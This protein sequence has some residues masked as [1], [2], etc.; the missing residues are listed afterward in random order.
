MTDGSAA[1][2][3]DDENNDWHVYMTENGVVQLRHNSVEQLET[4][5]GGVA[6]RGLNVGSHNNGNPHNANGIQVNMSTDEKIVLSG[7]NNP[8]I[9]W[10]EG[11]TDR[12]YIQWSSDDALL[13]KNQQ[14]DNFDF[15]THDTTGAV[16]IR[17][18]GSDNDTFGSVYG[19]NNSDVGQIGFLD[20]DQNWGYV[21]TGDTSHQWLINNSLKLRL[22]SSSLELDCGTSSTLNVK[23]DDAGLAMVRVNGDGQGTGAVEVGQSDTYGGGMFYNGDGS[24]AFASG[25]GSD[26][27][28]FYRMSNGTRTTVFSY[29]YSSNSV[30]FV[31]STVHPNIYIDDNVYHNGDSNTYYGFHAADQWRVVTGGSERL[32][33]NNTNTTVQN[34]LIVSGTATFN[35]TVS[36]I[37]AS[38][39]NG[40]FWE[41]DQ[42]ITSNQT[43]TNNKNA[44]SAGP[45]TINNNVTVTIG[46]GEAWSIV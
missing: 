36:G 25:E 44:M 33:V 32:E 40:Y 14:A 7:S 43:I 15:M 9:R 17:L 19:S 27:I 21:I 31:G 11:T 12:A 37:T 2:I 20:D 42:T 10:Q 18:R 1:G 6:V 28:T 39:R 45:I 34:N 29:P 13:F 3:Y 46:D 24:P 5:S 41:N 22:D 30:T 16:N 26:R 23:C 4:A 35:G 38:A 8:Y